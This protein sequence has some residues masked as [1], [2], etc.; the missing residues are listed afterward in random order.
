MLA[1]IP[2]TKFACWTRAQH[3]WSDTSGSSEQHLHS[4]D[5][6]CKQMKE[7]ATETTTVTDMDE[8][9]QQRWHWLSA[10]AAALLPSLPLVWP[11]WCQSWVQHKASSVEKEKTPC[12]LFST[13]WKAIW[14]YFSWD[15]QN[16]NLNCYI[17]YLWWA[18]YIALQDWN[19]L[20][21]KN[22]NE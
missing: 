13:L 2:K 21:Y 16:E 1:W 10:P 4:R 12:C 5:E 6:R 15:I 3:Q 8:V 7:G 11:S 22:A 14:C 9:D 18:Y 20:F 19:L 17:R